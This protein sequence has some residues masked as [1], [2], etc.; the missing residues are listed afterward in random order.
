[1]KP[2]L[3][4]LAAGIGSRYGGLKQLDPMGPHGE[5]VM[6]YAVFDAL[7]AGFGR[8]VFVVR[9]EFAELFHTTIGGRYAAQTKVEYAFQTLEDLPPGFAVPPGRAKPW[10]TTQAVLAARDIIHEPFAV[11]NADDFYGRESYRVM[12]D[13]LVA[14]AAQPRAAGVDYAM[15]GYQLRHTLSDHGSVARGVCETNGRGLLRSVREMTKVVSV[16]GRVENREDPGRPVALTGDEVVSLNFW[17][18]TPPVFAQFVEVFARFLDTRRG[19]LTA[20]CYIPAAIDTLI[21]RNEARVHVLPTSASWFGVTYREDKPLVMA[22]IQH[23][24][25]AGRYP[26]PLWS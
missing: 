7:R 16:D 21:A 24:V 12:H 5:T 20:E 18:F 11:I 23:L 10:G 2:T 13:F 9:P 3:L 25:E 4:I 1:M 15:I 8:V 22:A 19:D 14:H 26:T 6:D 17:G